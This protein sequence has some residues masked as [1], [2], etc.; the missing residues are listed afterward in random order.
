[1]LNSK[2]RTENDADSS[3]AYKEN[4]GTEK[5]K[6]PS[7]DWPS[8]GIRD[9]CEHDVLFG[10]GG[11]TNHRKLLHVCLALSCLVLSCLALLRDM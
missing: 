5:K 6:Q 1:M 2:D 7:V 3:R 11:G 4:Q 9:P 10:R 8:N